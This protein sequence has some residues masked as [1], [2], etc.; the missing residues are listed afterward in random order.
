MSGVLDWLDSGIS[1]IGSIAGK[2]VDTAASLQG[3]VQEV[4]NKAATAGARVLDQSSTNPTSPVQSQNSAFG[5]PAPV[6]YI[7][8]G[9]LVAGVLFMLY[10]AVSK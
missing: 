1:K 6:V 7:G 3:K 2:A 10:R 9:L 5:L 8:G 4:T